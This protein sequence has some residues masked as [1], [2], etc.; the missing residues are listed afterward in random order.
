MLGIPL[1]TG[2]VIEPFFTTNIMAIR[3]LKNKN[4]K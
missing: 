1:P 4:V 3:L 2:K